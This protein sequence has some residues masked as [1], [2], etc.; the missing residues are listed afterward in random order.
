MP[1]SLFYG[2][3]VVAATFVLLFLG[4]GIAYSF[5]AF[6]DSL[7]REFQASRAET[8]LVFSIAGFLY[9][10]L[11]A[12]SGSIADR[13][14]P[15]WV[16][17]FGM[18]LIGGGLLLAGSTHSLIMVYAGYGAAVGAGIGFAYVPAIGAVQR[19]FIRRRGFASGIAV[20]GIGFGTLVM[21]WIAIRLIEFAGWRFAYIVLGLAAA[22]LGIAASL[23]IE[24]S[25]ARRNLHAD[26]DSAAP[27]DTAMHLTGGATVREALHSR[28][29]W[30][31]YMASGLSGFAL[32][33]PFVHLAP[34]GHDH[35]LSQETSVQLVGLI[36][37][38]SVV[39]RFL[40]G[41]LADRFGRRR[42]YSAMFFGMTVM[43]FWWLVTTSAW[44]LVAFAI[45]F[46]VFYG[47][48][49]ALAPALISDYFGARNV[50]ALIGLLY[51][52]V[53][54][55]TLLGPTL[56]GVVFDLTG[57]YAVPIAASAALNLL[58]ALCVAIAP[59]PKRT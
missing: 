56:A 30:L 25:P 34:Y 27:I 9:F 7:Q 36:G 59:E 29:F 39:G 20:S 57:S 49:V 32:F 15:R 2:W 17:A 10:T 16:C 12:V 42:A 47:G 21:P 3:V 8:S 22:V 23:L 37:A 51:T 52:S 14:G 41:G 13:I 46:G 5:S 6:F 50:G 43:M 38:G 53:S 18:G 54:I 45:P 24:P 55:G 4:F 40:L 11:G 35:G 1:R 44:G 33:V 28:P 26:G 58:A 48:F 31:L 19:W